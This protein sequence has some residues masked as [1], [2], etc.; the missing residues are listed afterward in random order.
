MDQDVVKTENGK[1]KPRNWRV[2]VTLSLNLAVL[3]AL[4]NAVISV[5]LPNQVSNINP[6]AESKNLAIILTTNMLLTMFIQPIV[7][8]LSDR[9]RSRIGKRA[10]WI[11]GGSISGAIFLYLMS[12]QHTVLGITIF[13][14]LTSV[15]LNSMN[16][17]LVTTIADRFTSDERGVVSGYAGAAQTAG[18]TLGVIIAGYLAMHLHLGYAVFSIGIALFCIF[19]VLINPEKSSVDAVI[20]PFNFKEFISQF[21][22]NPR[23]YPDFSWA[24]LGRFF[25]QLGYQGALT[26]QL[27]ILTHY[28][29]LKMSVANHTIGTVSFIMMIGLL[30][31]SIF[32]GYLSDFFGR[33]KIFVI[34]A[35]L[36]MAGSLIFPLVIK[37]VTGVL[38][39]AGIMGLGF[40]VY[41]SVDYALMTDVLPNGG[42]SAGKDLGILTIAQNAPQAFSPG[43]AA[44]LLALTGQNYASIFIFGIVSVALSTLFILPIK[45]VK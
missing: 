17:P 9:T 39:Y 25:M 2:I 8:A 15:C 40:G 45:S 13:W 22:V 28:I 33:K 18:G 12:F 4:Y 3:L 29:G 30:V 23:Q 20:E 1:R 38:L 41:Q 7:G 6:A 42:Q 26:Y 24:F 36:T 5:F 10:P 19:F 35:A 16:G 27:Y 21:W 34:I 31:S 14:M 32:S 44:A 11:L 37:S 43:I